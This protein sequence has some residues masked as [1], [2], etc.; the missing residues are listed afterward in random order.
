MPAYTKN[1][2]LEKPYENEG[3]DVNVFNKNA[4]T[5]DEEL[6]KMKRNS[7]TVDKELSLGSSNP[8]ENKAIT[9][10]FQKYAKGEGLEFSVV[11]GL[12]NVTYDDGEEES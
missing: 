3:Y 11:N 10:E 9:K 8:V 1:Y 2:G 4:D 5:I 6:Q 12:L 7:I